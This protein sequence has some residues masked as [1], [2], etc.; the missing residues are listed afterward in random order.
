MTSATFTVTGDVNVSVTITELEGGALQ[1]DLQVLD[2]TGSIGDL[3]ALFFDLLDDSLTDGLTVTGDD[4]TGVAFKADGVTKVDNYTNMNG[5]VIHDLGRFDGGVQF[6]TSGIATDDIRSTSFVLSH[7]TESLNLSLFSLQDFGVRLTS[8]GTEDGAREDSLKLGETAPSF[9]DAPNDRLTVTEDELFNEGQ[10]EVTDQL[11]SFNFSLLDNDPGA[12]KV[13]I[14]SQG[15]FP[16]GNAFLDIIPGSNG[17]YLILYEDGRVD[18]ST[19]IEPGAG[20]FDYLNDNET[21]ETQF[22]YT[23]DNG[24]TATLTVTVTGIG[25]PGDGDAGIF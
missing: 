23:T 3:N 6:G 14:E 19:R 8:V 9:D 17:G 15:M 25:S 10:P 22:D 24:I 20:D 12:T 11:D 18:F 2:D 5:E 16:D 21:A 4:V 7:E 1:F 13:L